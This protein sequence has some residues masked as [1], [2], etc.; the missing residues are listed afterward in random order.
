MEAFSLYFFS[1]LA[2]L[3]SISLRFLS[4]RY[5]SNRSK[6]P[7]GTF[8]FPVIGETLHFF[9]NGPEKFIHQRMEKYSEEVFATS[10]LGEKVAV[11]CGAAGNKFLLFTANHHLAPW[12]P[13]TVA[14]LL[15][16]VDSP[17]QS[18]KEI[19]AKH[20]AFLYNEILKPESLRQ[21][22]TIMDSFARQHIKTDWIPSK[23]EVVK[24]H[25][26]SQKY[27]LSL[28]CRLLLGV[29]D[30]NKV[31]TI[32]DSFSLTM[33]GMLSM[34]INLPGT[35]YNRAL[36]EIKKLKQQFLNIIAEKKKTVLEN[37]DRAS[38]DILSR[39]LMNENSRFMSD[40]EIGLYLLS[41]MLPSYES[42]S[43]SITFVLK[44]LAELPHI[45]D[46]VYKGTLL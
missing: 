33:E 41:L 5:N 37:R 18:I 36:K 15:N 25:P 45:Y 3:V 6:Y 30:A 27:T 7:P 8:G 23:S 13:S 34:P 43:A 1:L 10:L 14:K 22:I 11:V 29:E 16:W 39:T 26:L 38:S 24:I 21:H 42:T 35:T 2:I 46:G 19:A 40:S 20:R 32:S 28:A 31:Q 44:Y 9:S 17:G 4:Q 12:V